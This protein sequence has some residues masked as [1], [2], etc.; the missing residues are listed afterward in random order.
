M[1]HIIGDDYIYFFFH[2]WPRRNLSRSIGMLGMY[3]QL[4]DLNLLPLLFG[5]YFFFVV[6]SNST[7]NLILDKQYIVVDVFYNYSDL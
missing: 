4:I 2:T 3:V 6:N 7:S 5:L 1:I